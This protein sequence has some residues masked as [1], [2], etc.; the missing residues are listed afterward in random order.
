[1]E[2]RASAALAA[3]VAMAA[4]PAMAG[5]F[6]VYG[7][8]DVTLER[9]KSTGQTSGP[10][11]DW[12][13]RVSS[14]SSYIGFRG[15]TELS[16]QRAFFQAEYGT[17]YD[18]QGDGAAGT[19][20]FSYRDIFLGLGGNWGDIRAG[21][22]TLPIRSISGKTNYNPGSTSISE[23]I[24]LVTSI[25]GTNAGFHSRKQNA[26]QYTTPVVLNG[27]SAALA[28]GANEE[29]VTGA[30]AKNPQTFG[31]GLYWEG[32]GMLSVYYAYEQRSDSLTVASPAVSPPS[33]GTD[34]RLVFRLNFGQGTRVLAGFDSQKVDGTY[35]AGATAG[36]GS[37]GR[38]A[39]AV[40][41]SQTFRQHEFILEYAKARALNC[42]G[43]AALVANSSCVPTSL[44]TVKDTGA[45]QVGFVYH[46]H[47]TK[48]LMIQAYLTQIRNDA[49]ASYDF[50][51]NPTRNSALQTGTQTGAS[52]TGMGLGMRYS[53]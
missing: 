5:E 53:F 30:G 8:A 34:N 13:N 51:V 46:Y 44:G 21:Q 14:N 43:A 24:N 25:N 40:A 23:T 47:Y 12:R 17:N 28:Y 35:G 10:Q 11:I 15:Q 22:L 36:T 4:A 49:R 16:G 18:A 31:L 50:D 9:V 7:I 41:A 42:E 33:K 27:F 29:R 20:Q 37:V 19:N 1:M 32:P 38:N 6:A 39:W 45:K 26:I 2:S 48:D 52:P 3:V